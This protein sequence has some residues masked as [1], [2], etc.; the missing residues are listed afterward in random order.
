[1][2]STGTLKPSS[3]ELD[4]DQPNIEDYLPSGAAIQ[5]EPRGKLR[6]FVFSLRY[7]VCIVIWIK[8]ISGKLRS[9]ILFTLPL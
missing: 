9:S 5:Q 4:L 8:N 7:S 3:S 2:N 6:L 1:M